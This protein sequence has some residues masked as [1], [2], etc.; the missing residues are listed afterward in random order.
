MVAIIETLIGTGD[1]R[2]LNDSEFGEFCATTAQTSVKIDAIT[3]GAVA[4]DR[5]RR[6]VIVYLAQKGKL[7]PRNW[8]SICNLKFPHACLGLAAIAVQHDAA[9]AG[10]IDLKSGSALRTDREMKQIIAKRFHIIARVI[11]RISILLSQSA[12][13][14]RVGQARFSCTRIYIL[15]WTYPPNI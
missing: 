4:I 10:L 15:N 8:K 9:N 5:L 2:T 7:N 13:N 12:K 11:P 3:N 1:S 14:S 6:N